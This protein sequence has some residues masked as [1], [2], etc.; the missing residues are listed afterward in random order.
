M[1]IVFFIAGLVFLVVGAELLVKGSSNIA[2]L[3]KI[4]SLML[5]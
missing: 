3:F 1:Y 5:G 4:P 2:T